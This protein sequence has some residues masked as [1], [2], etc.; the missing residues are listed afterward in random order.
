MIKCTD[1]QEV[2][3]EGND[4][5]HAAECASCAEEVKKFQFITSQFDALPL[6]SP[7]PQAV[8]NILNSIRQEPSV[9]KEGWFSNFWQGIWMP[10]PIGVMAMM[11]VA[12]VSLFHSN[13]V[14]LQDR[15]LDKPSATM[16]LTYNRPGLIPSYENVAFGQMPTL[17]ANISQIQPSPTDQEARWQEKQRAV[18]EAEA[19]ALMMRGRRLKALGRVDLALND[20]ETITRFYP[21]YTYL[22]DVLMY[23]A[24]CYAFQGNVDKAFES[25]NTYVQKYPD[26]RSVVQPMID[27]LT[28]QKNGTH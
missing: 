14:A 8:Q 25:L 28:V 18:L 15:L 13:E 22:G 17:D 1:F 20:F 7:S 24:Q 21:D 10:V 27:Q 16:G 23:R 19:D 6:V 11:L 4:F 12:V 9:K 2:M 3:L 5:S 26:K